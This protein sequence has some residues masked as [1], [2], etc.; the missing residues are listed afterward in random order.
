MKNQCKRFNNVRI[1]RKGG[2]LTM[3]KKV[4]TNIYSIALLGSLTAGTLLPD[5]AEASKSSNNT[6]VA[7]QMEIEFKDVTTE[8]SAYEEIIWAKNRGII[9]G[10]VD[11]TFKPNSTI[12]EAE[13][14]RMLSQF[15]SLK[16]G[17][18]DLVKYTPDRHWADEY[19]DSL[20]AY[21]TP[22]N[23][24]FDNTLRN[25][26][27][28]SG[29]VAQAIG[30]L[31]G[32]ATSLGEAIN[33]MTGAGIEINQNLQ[34]E[35]KDLDQ[36]FSEANDLTRAQVAILLFRLHKAGIEGTRDREEEINKDQEV[37]SLVE[38]A[39]KG[40]ST[41]N[42]TLR[43]GTLGNEMQTSGNTIVTP[44][45]AYIPV[46]TLLQ[47]PEL[48][49]GCEIVSLT[50]ILNYYGYNVSKMAMADNYLPKQ[51]FSWT[52]GKRIG[53]NPYKMY[54]GNPR[55]KASGW[56]SF[57]P[58]IVEAANN[59]IAT[60]ENKMKATNISGSSKEQIISYLDQG[61]PI[62]I[63]VTL[64]LS[65]PNLNSHW[66]LSDTGEYYKAYT[67]L[68]VVVLNGYKDGVVHVMNPLKGQVEYNMDAFF[69][70]YE[71]M[72]KH[73]LILEK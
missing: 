2:D 25:K 23:G 13:F 61:I 46:N 8:Y 22:L 16:D 48:P 63:W 11:G 24:Y 40:M 7:Y 1:E 64:D 20:A 69:K 18:R 5:H 55:S 50:A 30:Y 57:A 54:A 41:L 37:L 47:D 34:F 59:Y 9:N 15:L 68:H 44:N 12:T 71:G 53:P 45:E 4:K 3:K 32:N 17:Q 36:F 29:V 31:T 42:L 60:Q 56:Y 66:Y 62:V 6:K 35:G 27:V 72:G 21:G 26:P 70:S 49:N 65:V 14:V 67:N 43:L 51:D 38:L 39:N 33:F 10:Y 28:K 58:P 19:Y 52:Q 73:A